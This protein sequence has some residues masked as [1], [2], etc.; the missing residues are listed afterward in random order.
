MIRDN[1]TESGTLLVSKN[2]ILSRELKQYDLKDGQ[3]IHLKTGD[4]EIKITPMRVIS[5]LNASR[6]N[7]QPKM[8]SLDD[9]LNEIPAASNTV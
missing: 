4:I 3:T 2:E 8:Q 6:R 1:R 7:S 5:A 9:M